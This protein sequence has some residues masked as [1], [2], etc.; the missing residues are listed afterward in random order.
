MR[1]F[2]HRVP[3]LDV[4][5]AVWKLP[6][7]AEACALSVPSPHTP[8]TGQRIGV[9]IRPKTSSEGQGKSLCREND[10]TLEKLRADL[11]QNLSFVML[12]TIMHILQEGEEI[13]QTLSNKVIRTEA[14]NKFFPPDAQKLS[15]QVEEWDA[16]AFVG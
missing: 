16:T 10:L 15:P 13:P 12:P 8:R 9:L 7:V 5:A 11:S 1:Y 2:G 3:I 4:E 6:Y 14:A